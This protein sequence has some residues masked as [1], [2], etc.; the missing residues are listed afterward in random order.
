MSR[1]INIERIEARLAPLAEAT[2]RAKLDDR[3]L[4]VLRLK[5]TVYLGSETKIP[6]LH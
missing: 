5:P 3:V 1:R 6:P 2:P 4:P